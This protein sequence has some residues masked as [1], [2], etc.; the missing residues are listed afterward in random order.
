M[1]LLSEEGV[2]SQAEQAK[3]LKSMANIIASNLVDEEVQNGPLELTDKEQKALYKKQA[4]IILKL[5][6]TA[7]NHFADLVRKYFHKIQGEKISYLPDDLQEILKT[8]GLITTSGTV[9]SS[10]KSHIPSQ[11]RKSLSTLSPD[12]AGAAHKPEYKQRGVLGNIAAKF[13]SSIYNPNTSKTKDEDRA[14][15]LDVRGFKE[16]RKY[17]SQM[18]EEQSRLIKL[19]HGASDEQLKLIKAIQKTKKEWEKKLFDK[20]KFDAN[21][22]PAQLAMLNVGRGLLGASK[23]MSSG[24]AK[25]FSGKPKE[26][27]ALEKKEEEKQIEPVKTEEIEAKEIKVDTIVVSK[28]SKAANDEQ[29]GD[30][31]YKMGHDE[32]DAAKQESADETTHDNQEKQIELVEKEVSLLEKIDAHILATNDNKKDSGILSVL[33]NLIG[34]IGSVLGKIGPILTTLGS[35]LAVAAAAFAGFKVGE[36]LMQ[37]TGQTDEN[38]DVKADSFTHRMVGHLLPTTE[39]DM[40]K[41]DPGYATSPAGLEEEKRHQL[42][43]AGKAKREKEAKKTEIEPV[44]KEIAPNLEKKADAAQE[45]IVKK[46]NAQLA[47]SIQTV[48]NNT[49]VNNIVPTPKR[50]RGYD[51]PRN[52]DNSLALYLGSR[53]TKFA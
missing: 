30:V 9:S 26:V 34:P 16:D 47:S 14:S 44:K 5:S 38:G 3:R 25:L 36:K 48:T 8:E 39:E 32:P 42:F 18:L 6:K 28:E 40:D 51:N 46:E 52:P 23:L 45:A 21:L 2:A 50:E 41:S 19:G 24:I 20:E 12:Q 13:S 31:S 17:R 1:A 29:G 43:L 10:A 15:M 37:L 4:D 7:P 27:P 22:M 33:T 11:L 35:G 53:V 49:P